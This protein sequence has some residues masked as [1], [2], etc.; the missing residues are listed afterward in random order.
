VEAERDFAL[1]FDHLFE[2]YLGFVESVKAALD[3]CDARIRD[4]WQEDDRLGEAQFRGETHVDLL[5]RLRHLNIY[6]VT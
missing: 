4:I 5:P 3:Y 2:S 6:Q 1:I